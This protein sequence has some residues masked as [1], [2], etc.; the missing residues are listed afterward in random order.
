[1]TQLRLALAQINPVIGDFAGN[2]ERIVHSV[3]DAREAGA[4]LI[5]VGEM[6]LTGYPVEDLVLRESFIAASQS[7][8]VDLRHRLSAEG[9]DDIA[10]VVGTL[11]ADGSV[12]PQATGPRG[13][14]GA[15]NAAVMLHGGR[16]IAV[17]NKHHLPNHGVFDEDRHFVPGNEIS[18]VTLRDPDGNASR[19]IRTS[20]VVCAD[21]WYDS[22]P[23]A[24]CADENVDL[25]ICI[26]ASPHETG[27]DLARLT[28]CRRVARRTGAI[29]A[30]V[31]LVGGQDELV[32]DG[33]SL[34]VHPDGRVLAHAPSFDESLLVVD[35]EI[36]QEGILPNVTGRTPLTEQAVR[37]PIRA[38]H[39]DLRLPRLLI[40]SPVPRTSVRRELSA[41]QQTWQ[42][43]QLGLADY[44]RKNGFHSVV[45][46]LSGGI[47]S[48]VCAALACDAL[49]AENVYGVS[50]PSEVS[51]Q[52]SCDDATDLVARTG[53]PHRV[54]PIDPMMKTFHDELPLTGLAAQNLQARIRAVLLMGI[55]N[56]E[57]H[58]LLCTGNKS[59]IAV[60]YSTMYGDA[61][62]GFAP[63]KDIYKT[64]LWQL[65]Q[66]RNEFAMLHGKQPPI[67]ENSIAKP[68]S[69]E[70]SLDQVDAGSLPPYELLD[71][72]LQLYIDVDWGCEEI[73]TAGYDA[74][75]VARVASMVNAAEHKR[76]QAPLGP[77]IGMKA[78]GRDRR[79]PITH[80]F[81]Q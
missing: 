3:R 81:A 26:N 47:D 43:L 6:A 19:D 70:L 20:M 55:S 56:S 42:T 60:G 35:L 58:L 39:A 50:L 25:L 78:F 4:Q 14:V 13:L 38:A 10:I 1:M 63:V 8:F 76:R 49:G 37:E 7:A 29:V 57:G 12:R 40:N 17:H 21:L 65:A 69:A 75:V 11:D 16:V 61:V 66:W 33:S 74:D 24:K 32:F 79:L 45:L 59:E 5:A 18:V 77:K 22:G 28:V 71:A 44:V 72:I 30:Y 23:I 36:A 46:G 62:G 15:R 27:K 80:C 52:H 2:I 67:P 41:E 9:L 34:V 53:M 51:S 64:D 68:P 48:S 31:N 73:I 54:I